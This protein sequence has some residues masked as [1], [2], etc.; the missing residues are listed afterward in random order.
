MAQEVGKTPSY[1]APNKHRPQN[2]YHENTTEDH[3]IKTSSQEEKVLQAPE[4]TGSIGWKPDVDNLRGSR[5]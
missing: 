1:H 3:E 5:N 2:I 4:L